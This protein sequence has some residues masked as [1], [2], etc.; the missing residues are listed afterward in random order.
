MITLLQNAEIFA[1][2]P[3]GQ[4]Q[5]LV[6][7]SQIAAIGPQLD[8]Q[9]SLLNTIDASGCWLIPGL[10]D[11]LA[12]II[13]GGGEGGFASR[14][15][16]LDSRDAFAAGVTTLVGVLGTDSITR[17]LTNLLAK[18]YA[19]EI[20]GLSCYC[21][22]G[23]YQVPVRTL[24]S[25]LAEDLL[26]IDKFIGVGEVAI[27]DHR[28]SQPTVQ[29]LARLA[30]DARVGGMLAGKAGIVSIH[31]GPS[32]AGL[33]ILHQVAATSDIPLSQF[34][35]THI[36]RNQALLEQ[37]FAFVQAGGFIDLT[38]STTAQELAQGE[39]QCAKALQQAV[40]R[41]L[42]TSRIT[43]SSDANAS[44]PLFDAQQQ[45]VGLGVGRIASLLEELQA[46]LRLGV[47]ADIAIAVVTANP[48]RVL[49]LTKK[50]QL[51]TGHDA[52]L[53]L[54]DQQ[55]FAVKAVMAKGIWRYSDGSLDIPVQSNR[56]LA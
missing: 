26:L 49:K 24:M 13:G 47:P 16:E 1:P 10:V 2:Q 45:F 48:A 35:P 42:D 15:P 11:S 39:I 20:E 40:Q 34:Y 54:L 12:H 8:L 31:T 23:S 5:L 29:E 25:T 36:N 18:A 28:S 6:S 21:H 38:T 53:V 14:T 50:G 52:D 19:L 44:L 7:G 51:R 41:G 43:F 56:L 27:A 46:S 32:P 17:T 4:Q 55:T 30:S 37:G 9:G 22:S 3:L 33:A